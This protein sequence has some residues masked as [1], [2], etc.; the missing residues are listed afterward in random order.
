MRKVVGGGDMEVKREAD[1][2]QRQMMNLD[3]H[4]EQGQFQFVEVNMVKG[5]K[6][7]PLYLFI[8]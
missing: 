5:K 7:H 3:E 2:E 4:F 6:G 8:I 1:T